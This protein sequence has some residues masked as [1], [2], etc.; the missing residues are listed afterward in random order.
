MLRWFEF[1]AFSRLKINLAKSELILIGSIPNMELLG[2]ELGCKVGSLPSTY[3]GLLL[4]N[5]TN[6][7]QPWIEWKNGSRKD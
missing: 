2:D 1:E 5:V 7:W 3:L 6:L 4:V